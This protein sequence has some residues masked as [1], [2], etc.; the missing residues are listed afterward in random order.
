MSKRDVSRRRLLEL[1]AGGAAGLLAGCSSDTGDTS[2][3]TTTTETT[4]SGGGEET[5]EETTTTTKK[6]I[7]Q[8]LRLG[9]GI[10]NIANAELNQWSTSY[11]W[12]IH[13]TISGR[14]GARMVQVPEADVFLMDLADWELD[15]GA[16]ELRVTFK[17]KLSWHKGTETVADV[18]GEDWVVQEKMGQ[19]MTPEDLRAENPAFVGWHS[20][21]KTTV[22][23]LNPEGYNDVAITAGQPSP[24]ADTTLGVYRDGPFKAKL[25]SI[26]DAS[27]R[28]EKD[29]IRNNILQDYSVS[30][31]D[32]PYLAGP[33]KLKQA[34]TQR[35]Q[36]VT[37]E[38]HWLADEINF[39][40][41]EMVPATSTQ[42]GFLKAKENKIDLG[43][44]IPPTITNPPSNLKTVYGSAGIG[45]GEGLF[46]NYTAPVNP[47]FHHGDTTSGYVRAA[48]ARQAV[49]HALNVPQAIKNR[50]STQGGRP[51]NPAEPYGKG[52]AAHQATYRLENNYPDFAKK[53][54]NYNDHDLDA[55]AQAMRD[56]GATK[57]GGTWYNQNGNPVTLDMWAYSWNT[58]WFQTF[59][60]NLKNFGIKAN[61]AQKPAQQIGQAWANGKIHCKQGWVDHLGPMSY[62]A[63]Q[64]MDPR[65]QTFRKLGIPDEWPVPPMDGSLDADLTETI[66]V[67]SLIE[68]IS[69]R[70][71]SE[72]REATK[73][74][75]WV[76]AY[77]LPFIGLHPI[78]NT[79]TVNLK[80]FNWPKAPE[81]QW[82]FA[83]E[84]DDG[85][86]NLRGQATRTLK[87]GV[88]VDEPVLAKDN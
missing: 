2:E 48:K 7:D 61:F 18:T 66:D 88:G 3:T 51:D 54:P 87:R 71:E 74:F 20:D 35:A 65:N 81:G 53:M 68:K 43:G 59:V 9:V 42:Q 44:G 47:F 28:D 84:N 6:V 30:L 4:E 75:M 52:C 37:N 69:S 11:Q 15:E 32:K 33:W 73:K 13:N 12:G 21:G 27:S 77:H 14:P 58:K 76:N 79:S 19:A 78:P 57:D 24:M 55:A 39:T 26:Q 17:D 38:D 83:D 82:V 29:K 49:A 36:F 22:F 64:H 70:P 62:V 1:S 10:S 72:N 31:G 41:F 46:I 16:K 23:E 40:G 34:A 80:E 60:S 50:F 8:T 25:E 67:R 56:A 85:V 86:W 5:T 63:T 45:F